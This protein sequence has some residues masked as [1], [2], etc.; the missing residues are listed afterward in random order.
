MRL[1]P[2]RSRRGLAVSRAGGSGLSSRAADRERVRGGRA[3]SAEDPADLDRA[4]DLGRTRGTCSHPGPLTDARRCV[5]VPPSRSRVNARREHPHFRSNDDND[6]LGSAYRPV[7]L[8]TQGRFRRSSSLRA[9]RR[10]LDPRN[11]RIADRLRRRA[12]GH[13]LSRARADLSPPLS[14][15]NRTLGSV[16]NQE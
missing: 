1:Q 5:R 9:S 4:V 10:R 13:V 11:Y 8:G 3:G 2:R 14:R 6:R 15:T 7:R 16:N 12:T